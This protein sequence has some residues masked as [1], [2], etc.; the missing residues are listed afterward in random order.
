[1]LEVLWACKC[2]P[3]SSTKETPFSLVYG[4]N[5]MIPMEIG[6]PFLRQK[7]YNEELNQKC[8]GTILDLLVK[9]CEKA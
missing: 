3:Q 4:T 7:Q 5:V 8:L 9:K 1:M 6:E 2:I